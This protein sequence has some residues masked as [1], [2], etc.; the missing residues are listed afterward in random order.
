MLE[1]QLKNDPEISK[2]LTAVKKQSFKEIER[3]G[4][5]ITD[6]IDKEFTRINDVIKNKQNEDE[7]DIIEAATSNNKYVIIDMES[8]QKM[9][10]SILA[11][12][13]DALS[14]DNQVV[15]KIGQRPLR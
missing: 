12:G 6:F 3:S 13:R 2:K 15:A 11:I 8:Y 10:L 9:I 1:E 4:L 5:E 14:C 7:N